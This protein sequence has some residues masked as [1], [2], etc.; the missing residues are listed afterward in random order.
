[1]ARL[2]IVLDTSVLIDVLRGWEPA[3]GW[4]A[5]LEGVPGCSEVTRVEIL[6]GM[7]SHE[8]DLSERILGGLEWTP[9]DERV[10]RRAGELGRAYRASHPGLGVADL[11]IAATA[12]ELG[13]PVATR[14]VRHFP[15]FEGLAA[16]YAD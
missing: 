6:R 10:S 12:V 15:M 16:P 9:V 2:R 14:N 7:R 3:T 4:F 11:L 5:G 1:V 8:R 13:A